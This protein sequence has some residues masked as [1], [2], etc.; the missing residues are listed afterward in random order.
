MIRFIS[1]FVS[2]VFVLT[3]LAACGGHRSNE[4]SSQVRL[5]AEFNVLQG[6]ILTASGQPLS[7][8]T[9][10]LESAMGRK[11]SVTDTAGVYRI[12]MT[13]A[14]YEALPRYFSAVVM[15]AGFLARGIE[16]AK[17]AETGGEAF[18]PQNAA[19][20]DQQTLERSSRSVIAG[21]RHLGNSAYSGAANSQFQIPMAEALRIE[22][23]F[24]LTQEELD[25]LVYAKLE[26]TARGVEGETLVV[27]NPDVGA[28]AESSISEMQLTPADGSSS[29][30]LLDLTP[31]D[32]IAGRNTILIASRYIDDWDDFEISVLN[33]HIYKTRTGCAGEPMPTAAPGSF[34]PMSRIEPQA[35]LGAIC[36][37]AF[38]RNA[39]QVACMAARTADTNGLTADDY[40]RDR[41]YERD[42]MQYASQ[43]NF[44]FVLN[45]VTSARGARPVTI[46]A[47]FPDVT[48]CRDKYTALYQWVIAQPQASI[49]PLALFERAMTVYNNDSVYALA[50]MTELSQWYVYARPGLDIVGIEFDGRTESFT[51]AYIRYCS[52]NAGA[53]TGN[54]EIDAAN[55]ES[56]IKSLMTRRNSIVATKFI[57]ISQ[58]GTENGMYYHYYGYFT[59]NYIFPTFKRLVTNLGG[60]LYEAGVVSFV[61]TKGEYWSFDAEDLRVDREGRESAALF[62]CLVTDFNAVNPPT[63]AT[64]W[65]ELNCA[66]QIQAPAYPGDFLRNTKFLPN[67]IAVRSRSL[68]CSSKYFSKNLLRP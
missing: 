57:P 1:S 66:N 16:F 33:L 26:L 38:D 7:D 3:S 22:V 32:L 45:R 43:A 11:T 47:N 18:A 39:R 42:L 31:T 25:A 2:Y 63:R 34:T 20:D 56:G 67:A 54:R 68:S 50:A 46:N 52:A 19:V 51:D 49:T 44:C 30:Q 24:D 10:T 17:T 53:C 29:T 48:D 62:D 23:S 14:E 6:Q 12:E 58:Y 4:Y 8:A 5:E 60:L 40:G 13:S 21:I 27:V 35:I 59:L 9:V 64:W 65:E 55:L 41:W 28:L 36:R 61:F 37:P 15:R